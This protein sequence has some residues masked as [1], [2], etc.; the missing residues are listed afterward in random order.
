[1]NKIY[2]LNG[3]V[4]I[5]QDP[6]FNKEQ[7]LSTFSS[8]LHDDFFPYVSWEMC[9]HPDIWCSSG[10]NSI[11]IRDETARQI[12]CFSTWLFSKF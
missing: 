4:I 1:M 2:T 5:P 6:I 11:N 9:L 10:G 7:P 3:T 12:A 8:L